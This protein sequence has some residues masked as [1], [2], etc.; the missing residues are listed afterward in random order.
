MRSPKGAKILPGTRSG[1]EM[2]ELTMASYLGRLLEDPYDP[3]LI[4]GLRELLDGPK[5]A[6]D[7]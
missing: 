7:S 5:P 1:V 2:S 3:E 6:N 4:E